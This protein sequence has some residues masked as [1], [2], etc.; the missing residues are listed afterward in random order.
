MEDRLDIIDSGAVIADRT[1][2]PASNG[3]R[4][5]NYIL[6]MIGYYTLAL[7]FGLVLGGILVAT[8]PE[9]S[10]F[11]DSD[12][13]VS[14]SLWESLLGIVLILVYYTGFEYLFKGKTLGKFITKTRAVT[15]DNQKMSL[16]TTFIRTLCR[17]VPFEAFSFFRDKPGG[18]HDD[19]S[20]T[21][22]IDDKDW[23]DVDEYI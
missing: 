6:D 16:K 12:P 3:K 11:D 4:F 19:W 15:E 7:I 17:L 22:V 23:Q 9:S 13:S 8:N 10:F 5:A 21:I 2:Q 18:W 20:K 14:A 1:Y